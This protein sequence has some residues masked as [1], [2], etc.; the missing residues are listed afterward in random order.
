MEKEIYIV[1]K[2]FKKYSSARLIRNLSL[3]LTTVWETFNFAYNEKKIFFSSKME[4]VSINGP[5]NFLCNKY[6]FK[7]NY[8][9]F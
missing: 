7:Q 5:L 2:V 8:W 3:V 4:D 6:D 1:N 9:Q